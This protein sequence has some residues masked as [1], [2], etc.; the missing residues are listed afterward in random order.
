M[1]SVQL[2]EDLVDGDRPGIGL[3]L[4]FAIIFIGLSA[5]FPILGVAFTKGQ[6]FVKN[7]LNW[8]S[9][10]IE[11]VYILLWL[12]VLPIT[13]YCLSMSVEGFGNAEHR[14]TT[15]VIL[16]NCST[17]IAGVETFWRIIQQRQQLELKN[18]RLLR[19]Q[20]MAKY[21][22][23]MN[24]LNPHFLFN[25]LNVL[26]YLVYEDQARAEQFIMKL[27]DIYRYILQLNDTAL[28]PLKTELDFIKSYLFLQQIRHGEHL[29]YEINIDD[30]APQEQLPPLTLE[31]LVENVIKHNKVNASSPLHIS[32]AQ[33]NNYL[34]VTN[35]L[36][37]RDD[38]V[39]PSTHVGIQNLIEKYSLLGHRIPEFYIENNQFIAKV[40]LLE[41]R[42]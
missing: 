9:T 30:N 6:K 40:P 25:S 37:P 2:T 24:Q 8:K 28:V 31:V 14:W 29:S 38:D 39:L 22:A 18:E 15:S 34:F 21:N 41:P 42:L 26:S 23:L 20:E 27:S 16:L 13:Y 36:Q 19:N 4:Q 17:I 33:K 5:V 3:W 32:I 35:D 11:I 10:L 1:A 12:I 7:I